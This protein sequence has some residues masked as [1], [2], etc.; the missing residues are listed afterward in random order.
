[1]FVREQYLSTCPKDMAMHLKEGKPETISQLA[2]IA[3]NYIEAHASDIV[4]GIDP[5][6]RKIRSLQT[7]PPKCSKCGK[8]GHLASQCWTIGPNKPSS[9]PKKP[10]FARTSKSPPKSQ[11]R[12]SPPQG[13]TPRCYTCHRLG[14]LA[15]DCRLR[16]STAAAEVQYDEFDDSQ[17]ETAACFPRKT[18]STYAPKQEPKCRAHSNSRRPGG[19]LCA[20]E[21]ESI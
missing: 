1:L 9:P 8:V 3:E 21:R 6:L 10:P 15:R 14:H 17:E 7:G 4:F 13:Y 19:H 5:K 2:E 18:A 12:S 20:P 16:Q 11:T